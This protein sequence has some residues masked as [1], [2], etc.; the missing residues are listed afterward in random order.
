[1]M[2]IKLDEN[3]ST[4]LVEL[5]RKNGFYAESVLEERLSGAADEDLYAKCQE[6][7]RCLITLDLDFSNIVRF[8]AEG[9]EGIIVIRPNRPAT[10][11]VMASMIELF[12]KALENQDPANCLWILEPHQLRIRKPREIE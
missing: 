10:L 8:P 12:L 4:A 6:E 7:E 1:M 9:T 11:D 5:L 3:F 2:R